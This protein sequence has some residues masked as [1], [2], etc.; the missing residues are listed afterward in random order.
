MDILQTLYGKRIGVAIS[1]GVDSTALLHYLHAHSEKG[2]YTL[3]AVHCEHGIRGD[4]SLRDQAF[5]EQFCRDL[6]VTLYVFSCD[7]PQ[8]A[9]REKCSLE[10]AA[11]NFRRE[12]FE[13]LL[14]D[15]K[16]DYIATA[17]HVLD[18]AETV[19]FRLARGTSLSGVSGMK[20]LD[21]K[22]IRPFLSWTKG[23]ILAYAKQ[24]NLRF[25]DDSTNAQTDATRNKLRLEVFPALEQAVDGAAENL[26]RFALLAAEDDAFLYALS[27]KLLSQKDGLYQVAFSKE[28]PLF[29]RACLTALKRLGV[30]RD[31]TS[32]HL[33]TL[34]DLQKLERGA[35]VCLPQKVVAQKQKNHIEIFIEKESLGAPLQTCVP[36]M[37]NAFDGGRYA[38]NVTAV[39]PR[40]T[41]TAWKVLQFDADKL[42]KE[43]VFRFREE[44]D[45]IQSFGGKKTLKKFLNEREIDPKERAW[46]P[47][48]AHP[49][50][51]QVYVICGV[52]ISKEIC[53]DETT[54]RV[55]YITLEKKEK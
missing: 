19:L 25:C 15:G 45:Y 26:A 47:L 33:Q 41:D 22:Y 48:L 21:G 44:G 20:E 40:I 39:C 7:C 55:L 52:E 43:A 38:V 36:F 8:R 6:G 16:A 32:A 1:G 49:T 2:G 18:E 50:Q 31:Y 13:K 14:N 12:C 27:E 5:V 30:E 3:C 46:L 11:R 9:Q 24:H 54:R 51:K 29:T 34:F 35:R 53:V 42:P 37:E 23:E 10:T 17:H 28:K 4:E